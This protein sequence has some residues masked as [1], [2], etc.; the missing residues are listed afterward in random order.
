MK[1]ER[2]DIRRLPGLPGPLRF[3]PDPERVT[4]VIGPNASGKTSLL[5]ALALL[6]DPHP[7]HA[8]VEIEAVFRDGKRRITGHA[9]GAARSWLEG[10]D[11]IARPDWP[12]PESLGAFLIRADDLIEPSLDPTG[13]RLSDQL[14]RALAG[15]LDVDA[16]LGAAPFETP[17]RPSKLAGEWAAAR[18]EVAVLERRQTDLADEV[19]RLEALRDR[20]DRARRAQR[21]VYAIDR[22]RQLLATERELAA[23][24]A[25]LAEYPDA[26]ARLNGDEVERMTRIDR[27]RAELERQIRDERG[28][29]DEARAER[30]R[31]GSVDPDALAPFAETLDEA[32][33]ALSRLEQQREQTRVE[34]QAA[35]TELK[36]ARRQAGA[37][38]PE[39]FPALNDEALDRLEALAE[40]VGRARDH[41][42]G[43][44]TRRAVLVND[45][46]E[47]ENGLARRDE[48]LA[49]AVA[50]LR[51]WLRTGPA[52]PAA[53]VTWSLLLVAVGAGAAWAWRQPALDELARLLAVAAA[54]PLTQLFAL[55]VRAWRVSRLQSR[56]P[57]DL[58]APGAWSPD[59]VE[60]RLDE[61]EAERRDLLD[62]RAR[63]RRAGEL[64]AECDRAAEALERARDALADHCRELGIAPEWAESTRGL[65]RLRALANADCAATRLATERARLTEIEA[66]IDRRTDALAEQFADSGQPVPD[67]IDAE[68]LAALRSELARVLRQAA[69]FDERAAGCK[70][71][72]R[73][74][75]GE[76]RDLETERERILE[77]ASLNADDAALLADRVASL[78]AYRDLQHQI[79]GLKRNRNDHRAALADDVEL[80]EIVE[81]GDVARL[82]ALADDV[83]REA[84]EA[85]ALAEDITRIE[86]ERDQALQE[87]RLNGLLAERERLRVALEDALEAHR[88]AAAGRFLL[89]R[90]RTG[91]EQAERPPLLERARELLG[92]MTG[93]RHELDFDGREFSAHDRETGN[94]HPL[95]ELSTATRIQLLLALRLAWIERAERD[96]PEL[97]VFLDEVLATTDP[98]RYRA[99]VEALQAIRAEGRQI[100]Y[101][102]SQPAD[103]EAWR[104][105]AGKPAPAVVELA[106]AD[107]EAFEFAPAPEPVC[108]D[109]ALPPADWAREAGIR[110]IDPWQPADRVALFH[111]GRDRLADLNRLRLLGIETLGTLRHA[112]ELGLELG[113]EAGAAETLDRRADGA[114]AW[115]A[116]WR[117]GHR[118]PVD[119]M[120]LRESDAVSDKFID[121]VLALNERLGGDARALI[122]ALREGDVSG[123]FRKKTDELEQQF[124]EAGLLDEPTPPT[125]AE[126]IDALMRTGGLAPEAAADL[127]RWLQAGLEAA[128]STE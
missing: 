72:L 28:A 77:R 6:L 71:R 78:E 127:N 38:D 41:V 8:A 73:Q 25:T 94:R 44:E 29:L 43:I 3:E 5:R 19:D 31:L 35:E 24:E 76:L 23:A 75:E 115:L 32:Q 56:W 92:R 12:G 60:T 106:G 101:L 9:F 121:K 46:P 95:A 80:L 53:W 64:G 59:V 40:E 49:R 4:V 126:L 110:P 86:M 20:R 109:P 83:G 98:R 48:Q 82:D 10:G 50:A 123:F 27:R 108:P 15:G 42:A 112:R 113:I 124:A 128:P 103:A 81:T 45:L 67:Q 70:K 100:I 30:A 89:E 65:L 125:D 14:R 97:P 116:R 90:A 107:G 114:E 61:L 62:I 18:G 120:M 91:H 84:S 34:V 88:D 99:V 104:R 54:V 117:R 47:F 13:D 1:L 68:R 39:T 66:E 57:H 93:G 102:S 122:E 87:H 21:R 17:S 33:R 85:D 58:D 118:K 111:V 74:L 16:V 55:G 11:A 79:A 2:L 37:I 63:R 26:L 22:A 51:D 7:A 36:N 69:Q 119:P 105:Y 52:R 96:G